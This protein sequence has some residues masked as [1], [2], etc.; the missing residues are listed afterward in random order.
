[1]KQNK[2]L[3]IEITWPGIVTLVWKTPRGM[4]T[5]VYGFSDMS[6]PAFKRLLRWLTA[7]NWCARSILIGTHDGYLEVDQLQ[8]VA[9]GAEWKAVSATRF[10]RWMISLRR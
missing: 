6:R 5:A 7:H 1:M 9:Q 2:T 10:V 8:Q 3:Q 4:Q